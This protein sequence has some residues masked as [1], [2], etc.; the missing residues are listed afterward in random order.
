[1]TRKK[2]RN[3]EDEDEPR[4]RMITVFRDGTSKTDRLSGKTQLLKMEK[5]RKRVESY[6][7]GYYRSVTYEYFNGRRWLKI[8]L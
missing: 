6:N 8:T 1:M 4:I 7:P 5:I 2:R 3:K